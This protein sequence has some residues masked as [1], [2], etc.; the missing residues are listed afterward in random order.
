MPQSTETFVCP[1]DDFNARY[2]VSQ[3]RRIPSTWILAL[4]LLTF[5]MISGFIF[6]TLPQMLAERGVPG[7]RIAVTVAVM[8]SP[9]FWSFLLAPFLDVRFRRR[10]YALVFGVL[11]VAA[12]AISA[13]QHGT[14]L[15]VEAVMLIG[16]TAVVLFGYAMGGWTGSLIVHG[17]G[18]SLGAWTAAFN[19][20][21]GGIGILFSG[22]VTQHLPGGEAAALIFIVFLLPLLVFPMIPAPPPDGVLANESFGRFIGEIASLIKRREVLVALLLFALPAA[23]FALTN[24]LGGWGTSF[25]ANPEL[26]SI[27]GGVGSVAAGIIGALLV[28]VFARR[29]PLRPL[30]LAIGLI[31]AAFTLSLLLFPQTP[32][33]YGAAFVGETIFQAAAFATGL[34]IVFEIVGPD[35]PLAA[36]IVALLCAT[37]NLPIVYME[38]VDGR[39]FDWRGING[40][41]LADAVVSGG[42]CIL[43]AILLRRWLFPTKQNAPQAVADSA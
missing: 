9:N 43:L 3:R 36:T 42:A 33:I 4:P 1:P 7:G 28:P 17:Q 41:L 23:S 16:C 26:V 8:T 40:A 34:A 13:S 5:G 18:G 19:I 24:V 31:G 38:I 39:G 11:A 30:Y 32:W 2:H 21:G 12:T 29:F 22:Y 14:V 15:Q 20:V 10:T 25:G 37:L 35:N 27:L 6:V